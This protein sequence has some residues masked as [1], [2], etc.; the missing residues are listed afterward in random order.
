MLPSSILSAPFGWCF[1][2]SHPEAYG[3]GGWGLLPFD[4]EER[5]DLEEFL[6]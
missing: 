3:A 5:N 6:C 4:G 2:A 1:P